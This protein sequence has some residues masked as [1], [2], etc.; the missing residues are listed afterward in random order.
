M[1]R[2]AALLLATV[3][4]GTAAAQSP[5]PPLRFVAATNNALPIAQFDASD[6]LVGGIVKDLGELIAT[7]LD[8]QAVFV[9][10]AGKRVSAALLAGEADAICFVLPEWLQGDF[11]WTRGLIPDASLVASHVDAPALTSLQQLAGQPLGTVQG[12]SYPLAEQVLGKGLKRSDV[13]SMTANLNRLAA[14]R[15]RYALVEKTSLQFFLREQTKAQV[16]IAWVINQF[17]ARCAFSPHS[18]V[19]FPEVAAVLDRLVT[20]GSV[21]RVLARY[22]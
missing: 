8:R 15:L 20:D 21:Q 1:K 13:P 14:G 5:P 22:R 10:M 16:R 3:L 7:G 9:P 11:R 2:L 4:A 17:D 19:P 18:G 12:Y 6:K